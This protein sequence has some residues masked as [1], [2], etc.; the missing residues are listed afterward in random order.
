MTAEARFVEIPPLADADQIGNRGRREQART[1]AH[2]H[3][4]G[5]ARQRLL[6]LRGGHP[7]DSFRHIA[8]PWRAH[9]HAEQR[10]G[11]R[12]RRPVQRRRCHRLEG[13]VALRAGQRGAVGHHARVAHRARG[14]ADVDAALL[15]DH[16]ARKRHGAVG[17]ERHAMLFVPAG[18]AHHLHGDDRAVVRDRH[19]EHV[20]ARRNPVAFRLERGRIER[21]LGIERS[22]LVEV[23]G[24]LARRVIDRIALV[25]DALGQRV[26][27]VA[28]DVLGRVLQA[29]P[30]EARS[31]AAAP[32]SRTQESKRRVVRRSRPTP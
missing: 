7:L 29:W 2:D 22:Q 11:H 27:I 26:V 17:R 14:V 23:P 5:N 12:R 4:R 30:A 31:R 18:I 24:R 25:E 20:A 3:P 15:A 10:F 32:R 16:V 19:L 6:E 9:Q 1:L 8:N 28:R 21:R 13:K